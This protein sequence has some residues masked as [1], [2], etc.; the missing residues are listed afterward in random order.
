MTAPSAPLKAAIQQLTAALDALEGAVARRK[1]GD[2][3]DAARATELELM[4]ADRA[5][6][7]EQLDDSLA[8]NKAQATLQKELVLRVDAAMAHVQ[9][10]LSAQTKPS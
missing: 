9:A 8:H 10:A 2:K 5:R 6:L 3:A 1:A 4:R 7:A